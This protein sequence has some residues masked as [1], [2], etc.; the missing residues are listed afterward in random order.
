MS[1]NNNPD[2][3]QNNNFNI[4]NQNNNNYENLIGN[5]NINLPNQEHIQNLMRDVDGLESVVLTRNGTVHIPN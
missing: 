2:L 3:G 5:S 4:F 1:N